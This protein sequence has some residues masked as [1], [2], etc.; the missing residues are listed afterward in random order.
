MLESVTFVSVSSLDF[1]SSRLQLLEFGLK[2]SGQAT[3]GLK[4]IY[5]EQVRF[6]TTLLRLNLGSWFQNTR[7]ESQHYSTRGGYT[8]KTF[9][10]GSPIL[11]TPIELN[12]HILVGIKNDLMEPAL[13]SP[14]N[15]VRPRLFSSQEPSLSPYRLTILGV[16]NEMV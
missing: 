7:L 11:A 6:G 10:G 9:M 3:A 8:R 5:Q 13:G 1:I 2:L 16:I 14:N 4:S 12:V 15:L